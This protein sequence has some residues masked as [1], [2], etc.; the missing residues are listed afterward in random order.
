MTVRDYGRG[1]PLGKVIDCVSKVNTG[2]KFNDDVFQFSVG[3]NGIGTKAVN[4]LSAEFEVA[5]F[6]EGKFMPGAVPRGQA[7]QPEGGQG[8]E[9]KNG[10]ARPLHA[11]PEDLR[12]LRR[13]TTSSSSRGCATTPTSTAAC[14][15]CT[16]GRRS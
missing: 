11:G 9:G 2:G 16:T 10:H 4:A 12:H 15:S 13:G 3:L 5:S 1:I 6:R 8:P 14:A 7:R